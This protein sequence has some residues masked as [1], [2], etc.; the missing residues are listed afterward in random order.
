M[1]QMILA[2]FVIF[3][4]PSHTR[5]P[6]PILCPSHKD[7]QLGSFF[8]E[9]GMYGQL[10][11]EGHIIGIVGARRLKQVCDLGNKVVDNRERASVRI[12]IARECFQHSFWR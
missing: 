9:W 6:G 12:T 1:H 5:P 10:F 8:A 2:C 7:W 4:C 3:A 11:S